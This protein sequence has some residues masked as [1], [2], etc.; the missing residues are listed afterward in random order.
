MVVLSRS[1]R[2]GK[3][4]A[5]HASDSQAPLSAGRG[6]SGRV[7]AQPQLEHQPI[8]LAA[9]GAGNVQ[10][11]CQDLSLIHIFHI[12]RCFENLDLQFIT[13]LLLNYKSRP[14]S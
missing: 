6:F 8:R 2:S 4:P 7:P 5:L 10:S 9:A 14:A 1:L 3:E 13:C 11:V 12:E